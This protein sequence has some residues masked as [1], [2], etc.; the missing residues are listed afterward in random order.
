[1]I[2]QGRSRRA[3]IRELQKTNLDVNL[4]INNLLSRPENDDD[5]D[6]V[7]SNED[8]DIGK[9]NVTRIKTAVKA[10]IL[11]YKTEITDDAGG[12]SCGSSKSVILWGS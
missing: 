3:I 1:M 12:P 4:T 9:N 11:N 2:L 10:D 6:G 5:D 7:D 8:E